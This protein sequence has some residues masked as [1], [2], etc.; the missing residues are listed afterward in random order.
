MIRHRIEQAGRITFAEFMELALYYPEYGYYLSSET[1]A[2]RAGDFITA[3]EASP[4]F[5]QAVA[6][7]IE[8]MWE[9][10]GRPS[11]FTIREYGAGSGSLILGIVERL[12]LDQHSLLN[13]LRYQPVELNSARGQEIAERLGDLGLYGILSEPSGEAFVGCVLANEFVDALPVHRISQTADGLQ[14]R[15]VRWQHGWFRDELGSLSNPAITERLESEGIALAP[16]QTAEVCLA[17][18][19]WMT[20]VAGALERGYALVIDYGYP[21]EELYDERFPDGSLRAYYQHGVH[22]DPYRGVGYQDLTAH[23]DFTALIRAAERQGLST[24]G[25]TTQANFLAGAGI[26]E[27]LVE[28]QQQP[29]MTSDRYLAARS[30]VLRMIDP[31]AMGRFRVLI[32]ARGGGIDV[33][34]VNQ[35]GTPPLPLRGLRVTI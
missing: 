14:E 12:Q 26:G 35:G 31:G 25:L 18:D 30:A 16:G 7:Q 17:S 13:H 34:H 21:A 29:G 10:L 11:T 33:D 5:G 19:A 24:L 3:P 6:R 32:L 23:V 9:R 8:E 2:G 1:R 20:E 4:L 27:F 28:L 22:D 15:Y